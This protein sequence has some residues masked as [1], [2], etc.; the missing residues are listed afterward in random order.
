LRI[1]D[2]AVKGLQPEGDDSLQNFAN[3]V[4]IPANE[5]A[6][7]QARVAQLNRVITERR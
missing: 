4:N 7:L 6:F 3:T 5:L 2:A 1:Y